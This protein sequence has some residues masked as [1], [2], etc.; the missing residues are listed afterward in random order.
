MFC[1]FYVNILLEYP[2]IEKPTLSE[3]LNKSV[4]N[5]KVDLRRDFVENEGEPLKD[6][7]WIIG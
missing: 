1:I 4:R 2:V 5:A 6:A 3:L 7:D